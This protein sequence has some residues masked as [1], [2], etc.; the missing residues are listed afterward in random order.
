MSIIDPS[1]H[2]MIGALI[3]PNM[4]Q[5]DF[6]GPFEAL[7]RVPNSTF[8]TIARDKSPVR[9]LKGLRILP[10]V[11][12]E[13]APKLDVLLVPGG[14]GQ[15]ALMHDDD[16]LAFIR[17]QVRH[18]HYIF[19][20]CTGALLCGAAGLLEGKR[21]TTHWTAMEVLR[22]YGATPKH[23]RVVVDGNMISAGG[24]T[25]GI[26]GSLVVVSLLRGSTVAEEIQ[27]YMAYEPKTP[28]T[29]GSPDTAPAHVLNAVTEQARAITEERMKT[30]RQYR[31]LRD[32][33]AGTN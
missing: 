24:V 21:A 2:L 5:C 25:A 20:V 33:A 29:A 11:S 31:T 12:M 17:E 4:D 6:T 7:A 19:S 1:V 9:D 14:Y 26:D 22:Y 23:E 13:D 30:A 32:R 15:E 28:F 18:A 8:V 27:L 16:I 3:F 10:D